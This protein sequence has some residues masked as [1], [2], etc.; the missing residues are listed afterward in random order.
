MEDQVS[1]DSMMNISSRTPGGVP[2]HCPLCGAAICV[3]PS[4]PPGD[5]PC[6]NCGALLWF[7]KSPDALLFWDDAEVQPLRQAIMDTIRANLGVNPNEPIDLFAN[8][9][10]MSD[11]LEEVEMMMELGEEFEL[12]TSLQDITEIRTVR[13]FIDYL[14][15][16][17]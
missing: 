16:R 7:T 2:N 12:T 8:M 15:R 10:E 5:A 14:L 1:A 13:D 11:S 6:P 17:S 9:A 3:E 4:E